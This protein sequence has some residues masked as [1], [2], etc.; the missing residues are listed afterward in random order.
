MDELERTLM[1]LGCDDCQNIP[2]VPL[3]GSIITSNNRS[4]QVMHNGIEVVAG[5]YHGDWMAQIIRGLRGHH[6]PQE[7]LLFNTL[8][9][10]V[11]HNSLIVEL[12]SFWAYYTLWYLFE[13]PGSTGIC[14]EPDPLHISIGRQNADH[15]KMTDRIKFLESWVDGSACDHVIRQSET[16]ALN[17]ALPSLNMDDIIRI[18]GGRVIELLHMD[19]QGAELSFL[20]SMELA[21]QSNSIRFVVISTHHQSISGSRDTHES[22]LK[23][24]RDLGGAVLAEHSITESYSG[25]GLIVASFFRQDCRLDIPKISR[26]TASN[27][28]FPEG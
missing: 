16:G 9:R 18:A 7:E 5:G 22:C 17:R 3:A 25:D 26:N 27:S 13:V 28:L 6:E 23:V 10:Y 4:F 20:K 2:K 21:V 12:G 19:V 15:N 8:L 24:I 11:R 1:T 14:I